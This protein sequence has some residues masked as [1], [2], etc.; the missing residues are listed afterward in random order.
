MLD[1]AAIGLNPWLC[2]DPRPNLRLAASLYGFL[3]KA[4][5]T[6]SNVGLGAFLEL[7]YTF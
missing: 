7:K 2:V 5:S 3:G 6:Y 1:H 4:E